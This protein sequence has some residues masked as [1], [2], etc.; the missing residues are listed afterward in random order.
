MQTWFFFLVFFLRGE[1]GSFSEFRS[2]S[3][4]RDLSPDL[5]APLPTSK[6]R[7]EGE[8]KASAQL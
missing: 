4:P 3:Q 2:L 5:E 6:K 7:K 1:K 8:K